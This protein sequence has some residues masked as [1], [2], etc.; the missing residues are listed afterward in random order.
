MTLLRE[1]Q[2]GLFGVREV[3]PETVQGTDTGYM[4][5]AYVSS[6]CA[7]YRLWPH[8]SNAEKTALL[9]SQQRHPS[10]S[11]PPSNNNNATKMGTTSITCL[12]YT[13]PSPRDRTRSRMP[14]SA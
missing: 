9:L 3:R 11:S 10:S 6:I 5:G 14:S 8:L 13:S 12:L 2:G 7:L 4:C 1:Q